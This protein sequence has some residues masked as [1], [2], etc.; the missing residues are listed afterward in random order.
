MKFLFIFLLLFTFSLVAQQR[1]SSQAE[2][3]I[4]KELSV[5]KDKKDGAFDVSNWLGTKTGFLPVPTLIT[6][7]ATGYGGALGLM[8]IHSSFAESKGYPSITTVLAGGT[9]NKTWMTGVYHMQSF[10]KKKI[11]YSG[12]I[13]FVNFNSRFYGLGYSDF[14]KKKDVNLNLNGL[15]LFQK[16]VVRIGKT[17]FFTGG[18]YTLFKGKAKLSPVP[19]FL[20]NYSSTDFVVSEIQG[21]ALYDSRNNFFSPSDGVVSQIALR[22]SDI[23]LGASSEYVGLNSYVIGYKPILKRYQ[24]GVK[25]AYDMVSDDAPF[26]V[27]PFVDNRGVAFFRYQDQQMFESEL[28]LMFNVTNRWSL[29]GFM[30]I[31]DA[32]GTNSTFF[33]DDISTSGGF[34]FRYLIARKFGMKMGVDFAW[35]EQFAFQIV[36]GSAWLR[37]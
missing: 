3:K 37:N 16:G 20:H 19:E 8:F 1:D 10:W 33:E 24:I 11:R 36:V 22:Y 28:E 31:G 12:A 34:G 15:F 35:E 29:L 26:F 6:N 5:F 7:P 2:N 32:F 23:W 9:Q 14:F 21:I 17:N 30:G 25:V 18:Q 27:Q 13:M 4:A